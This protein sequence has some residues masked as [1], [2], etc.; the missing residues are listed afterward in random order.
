MDHFREIAI[1]LVFLVIS[2]PIN[3]SLV[4]G[5]ILSSEVSGKDGLD[6]MISSASD[7][8]DYTVYL[9]TEVTASNLR[10][11]YPDDL[12]FDTCT[13]EGK[14]YVCTLR[15]ENNDRAPAL[16]SYSITEASD[17][18]LIGSTLSGQ[19]YIDGVSP[20]LE[21]IEYDREGDDFIIR[22]KVSDTACA[23]CT[24][25]SGVS[26]LTITHGYETI[27]T[28]E[29]DATTCV[30]EGEIRIPIGNVDENICVLATDRV[31][32]TSER[33]CSDADFD[34][35]PPVV[36]QVMLIDED[37]QRINYMPA[38][39]L[40][41][42]VIINITE[43]SL[44]SAIGDFS[45][46][47][48]VT[49]NKYKDIAGS[50][51]KSGEDYECRWELLLD[52]PGGSM[53]VT[54]NATDSDGNSQVITSQLTLNKDTTPPMVLRL[55][56][57]ALLANGTL[58]VKR[59]DNVITVEM[60]GSGSG[61]SKAQVTMD[62]SKLGGSTVGAKECTKSGSI[63]KCIVEGNVGAAHG[64]LEAVKVDATDD[65]GNRMEVPMPFNAIVDDEGP[66]IAD[67]RLSNKCPYAGQGLTIEIDVED[68]SGLS[69][70]ASAPD[71]T[72]KEE[73]FI[74]ICEGSVC[75]VELY[76]LV[77]Y[78]YKGSVE[79][80]ITDSGGN[81]QKRFQS[82]EICETS[83]QGTPDLIWIEPG[84][85]QPIDRR[86]LSFL[87]T[88]AYVPLH[89]Q[90]GTGVTIIDKDITCGS[91]A[92]VYF[93]N[94][95][96]TRPTLVAKVKKGT[97]V[98][99]ST[100]NI[101]CRLEMVVRKGRTVFTEPE[102]EGFNISIPVF[103]NALGDISSNAQDKID[104]ADDKIKDLEKQIKKYDQYNKWLGMLCMMAETMGK[105]N[106]VMQGIKSILWIY[107]SVVWGA[108]T[109]VGS[110]GV[111]TI[112]EQITQCR[113]TTTESWVA[114]CE[115]FG[116]FNDL[117][118][119]FIWPTGYV[120]S[121]SL[122]T[123]VKYGCMIYSC[124]ICD[125]STVINIGTSVAMANIQPA[126]VDHSQTSYNDPGGRAPTRDADTTDFS[127]GSSIT[128]YTWKTKP[129]KSFEDR[130][131]DSA[132][133]TSAPVDMDDSSTW[134][135]D[136]YKSMNYAYACACFPA[137]IYNWKK[138][139]Q[140]TCML[141]NCLEESARVGLSFDHCDRA[142][143][144]RH[145]LYI[146]SAQYKEHGF[147]GGFLEGLTSALIE[148]LPGIAIGLYFAIYC[149]DYKVS[150]SAFCTVTPLEGPLLSSENLRCALLSTAVALVDIY[151]MA[152]GG[153]D[154][155][156]YDKDPGEPDYCSGGAE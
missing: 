149:A 138:E 127:D 50:C 7:Y 89:I 113:T 146:E 91:T 13:A 139:R 61:Y 94:S 98:T 143:D 80:T 142:Y 133:T 43:E 73:D 66:V 74:G 93:I 103:N 70:T 3:S 108:C 97:S 79:L 111:G 58:V 14:D 28:E 95:Q 96:S 37:G 77:P 129:P 75:T 52:G 117:I 9:N 31:S 1:A 12:Q 60:D 112:A 132:A 63:W 49:P 53:S 85:P 106:S 8:I 153:L 83:D 56:T 65:A 27:H 2:M 119:K 24:A 22:Y 71:V 18:N 82:V 34:V 123:I 101:G 144:E 154:F 10:T 26:T 48:S 19:F 136:P 105:M 11:D 21:S 104:S 6:N 107:Y 64:T 47:N 17:Q 152:N 68:T 121:F 36:S 57:N 45:E 147:M 54:I 134:I 5:K 90:M 128:T 23:G 76:D 41:A 137:I 78:Y 16:I 115:M 4:L 46:L 116:K 155:S 120:P 15:T 151:D 150:S 141:K 51:T 25:C 33:Q 131:D 55:Y 156:K 145:C 102:I 87:D 140:I 125:W 69:I 114:S 110:T 39:P 135:F 35:K 32:R 109:T 30:K 122:G 59:G 38:L 99:G 84:V 67:V 118:E 29:I 40:K 100:I 126:T 92:D 81:V 72:Q 86:V 62:M 148:M 44:D 20:N 124:R 130:W 42:I 88:R